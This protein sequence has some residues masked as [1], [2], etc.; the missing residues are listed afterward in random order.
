MDPFHAPKLSRRKMPDVKYRPQ[1]ADA[2]LDRLKEFNL[3]AVFNGHWHGASE[4]KFRDAIITTNRCCALK[5]GNHDG[6]KQ[7]G[8]FLC[9]AKDGK[10]AREF[11]EVPH[12]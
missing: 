11:V 8:Y 4:K 12:D 1:N 2:I 10:I 7:K 3:Q 5:R 6:S 9:R